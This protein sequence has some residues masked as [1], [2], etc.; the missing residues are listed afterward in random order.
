MDSSS[1][2]FAPPTLAD[3]S[4]VQ[5][6]TRQAVSSDLAFANIFLLQEKYKTTIAYAKGF[7]FRH[8][9]GGNRLSGYAFPCGN[10]NIREAIDMI[11]S[12]AA[13]HQRSL[14]FCLLT[15]DQKKSLEELLPGQFTYALDRGDADY[16]YSHTQLAELP[17]TLFHAKRNHIAQFERANPNWQFKLLNDE[18]AQ[19][20]LYVAH[21]WLHGIADAPPAL[22]HEYKAIKNALEHLD[23]LALFGGVLYVDNTPISMSIGSYI[24]PKVADIHYEKCLPEWKKAYPLINREMARQLHKCDLINRE[25]DLNQPGLRQAKLSY[26]PILIHEKYSAVPSSVC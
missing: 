1:L 23:E 25:E 20:A 24:S 12:D 13:A 11:C 3:A 8:F 19:D 10:G 15:S 26:H 6:L 21:G 2:T 16:L 22:Q 18:T 14:Q 9:A 4:W 7:L 5:A 17:G